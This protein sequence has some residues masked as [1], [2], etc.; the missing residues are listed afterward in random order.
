MSNENAKEGLFQTWASAQQTLLTNW[1]NTLR[2]FSG[3]PTL[4]LWTKTVD[5]WQA[6]V[7]ETL[8]AQTKWNHE[9][10]QALEHAQGTPEELRALAR[11][12]REQLQHWT[13]A[14]RELWQDC[15][16]A[17]RKINFRPEPGAA[18][19][20]GRDLVQLWQDSAN[21]MIDAQAAVV[22]RLTGGNSEA[23]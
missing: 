4:E 12:G 15:F 18:A 16:D 3:T 11:D 1:L 19:Q 23:K 22:R 2:R 5:A 10:T 6:S 17:V 20:T 21:K 14:E 13:Q 8:A 7:K 9:W